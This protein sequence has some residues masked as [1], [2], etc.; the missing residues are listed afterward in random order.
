MKFELRPGEHLLVRVECMQMKGPVAFPGEAI[1]TNQRL[2]FQPSRLN[3]MVGARAWELEITEI[4]GV[5]EVGID[6][7]VDVGYSRG[8]NPISNGLQ[9][10][11]CGL[12]K[13]DDVLDG[14]HREVGPF[15][16]VRALF[17]PASEQHHVLPWESPEGRLAR[18]WV[19]GL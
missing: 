4:E 18:V 11:F 10:L 12:T 1:L 17:T 19:R 13:T 3:R 14:F 8:W 16:E 6:R 9:D 7:F 5:R 15:C 2:S